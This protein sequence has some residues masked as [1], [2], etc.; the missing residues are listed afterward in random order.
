M[1]ALAVD[2]L[3]VFAGLSFT[4]LAVRPPLG[5]A[6]AGEYRPRGGEAGAGKILF[7]LE[8]NTKGG[9]EYSYCS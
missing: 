3:A 4:L 5:V 8:L 9:L 6:P 1:V 7:V 2:S